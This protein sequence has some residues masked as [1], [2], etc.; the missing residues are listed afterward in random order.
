MSNPIILYSPEA[1][2]LRLGP[3]VSTSRESVPGEVIVF[4]QGYAR[5]DG[6]DY[7]D[8]ER[9]IRATGT[10]PVRVLGADEAVAGEGATCP[11]CGRVL[12]TEFGLNSHLRSH[13]PKA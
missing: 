5:V 2:G 10:P 7:P 1:E 11:V 4:E 8:L 12:K 6:D 13:A 3:G 9:W